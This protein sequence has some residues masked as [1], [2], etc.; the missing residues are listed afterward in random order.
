MN[1]SKQGGYNVDILIGNDSYKIS[2]SK[3]HLIFF[4]KCQQA[5]PGCLQAG[6]LPASDDNNFDDANFKGVCVSATYST[7]WQ[8]VPDCTMD[9]TILYMDTFCHKFVFISYCSF[10]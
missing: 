6:Y 3:T 10:C 4:L 5:S 7:Q 2:T 8:P 9:E 1:N